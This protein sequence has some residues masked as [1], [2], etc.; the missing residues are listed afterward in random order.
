MGKRGAKLISEIQ[1]KVATGEWLYT[2]HAA[3]R[4][5]ERNIWSREV[6]ETVSTGE[7]IEDYPQDK[8][9]PSCLIFGRTAAGRILHVQISYPSPDEQ[10][11]VITVYEPDP[12]EWKEG[13]RERR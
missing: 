11:K 9:G 5:I 8:Y 1:K 12:H 13:F 10:V 6:E 4:V 7:I 3:D 2:K